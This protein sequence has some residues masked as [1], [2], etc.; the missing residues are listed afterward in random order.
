MKSSL[1]DGVRWKL[2]S[3]KDHQPQGQQASDHVQP[4][5]VRRFV[6]G[7]EA[8]RSEEATCCQT[9][10]CGKDLDQA[11]VRRMGLTVMAA[12]YGMIIGVPLSPWTHQAL[13]GM[14]LHKVDLLAFTRTWLQKTPIPHGHHTSVRSLGKLVQVQHSTWW[15]C[16]WDSFVPPRGLKASPCSGQ[17]GGQ[18]SSESQE[19]CFC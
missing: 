16:S 7:S 12:L 9:T 8:S 4:F 5:G 15:F 3:Q 17:Q 10:S 1:A 11:A 6:E 18:R 14:P 19:T 2:H 13:L